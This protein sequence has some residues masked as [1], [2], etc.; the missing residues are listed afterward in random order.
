MVQ[1]LGGV[2]GAFEK[3]QITCRWSPGLIDGPQE[4]NIDGCMGKQHVVHA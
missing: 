1:S 4:D 3:V 2:A